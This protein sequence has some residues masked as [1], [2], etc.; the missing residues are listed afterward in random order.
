MV[1]ELPTIKLGSLVFHLILEPGF[2][3][4]SGVRAATISFAQS[5]AASIMPFDLTPQSFAGF[6]LAST[7]TY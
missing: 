7:I 6:R 1:R 3:S 2:I 4:L 5:S